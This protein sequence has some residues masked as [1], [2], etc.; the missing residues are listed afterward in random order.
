MDRRDFLRIS[1]AASASF[2][3]PGLVS[4]AFAQAPAGGG[5]KTYEVTTRVE[6]SKPVGVTRIW[7]PTPLTQDTAYHRSL[8]NIWLAEGGTV[9]QSVDPV[10]GA[11]M[12]WVEFPA[13]TSPYI[14][15]VS[16]FATRDI[17]VDLSRPGTVKAE[18]PAVLARYVKAT[19]LM[20]T[21]G[22]VK[23]TSSMIVQG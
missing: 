11:G 9:S 23:Q 1:G 19:D 10:Y 18:D 15:L 5:W 6:L 8:G 7:L 16:R 20:P 13:G 2:A 12:V 21:D 4:N 22:I 14:S 17:A 3:L